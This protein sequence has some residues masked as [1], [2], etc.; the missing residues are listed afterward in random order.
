MLHTDYDT[1]YYT[2]LERA[3]GGLGLGRQIR[4]YSDELGDSSESVDWADS[5]GIVEVSKESQASQGVGGVDS[6]AE[7]PSHALKWWHNEC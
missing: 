7:L 4:Q 1:L 2:D 6:V 5:P 3:E